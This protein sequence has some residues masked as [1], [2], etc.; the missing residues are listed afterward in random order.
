MVSFAVCTHAALLALLLAP[1]CL[2]AQ[3]LF[4]FNLPAQ[5][6]GDSLRTVASKAHVTVALHPA[7]V[8]GRR[9]PPLKGE[10]SAQAALELL[11][12]GSGLRVRVT[13]G[14]SYWIEAVPVRHQPPA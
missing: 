4:D 2:H 12:R 8:A 5:P 3:A 7:S 10:H 1:L 14:G 13:V 6:L 11:L 9:A